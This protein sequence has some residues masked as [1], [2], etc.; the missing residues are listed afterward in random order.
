MPLLKA[1]NISC[2][3]GKNTVINNMSFSAGK[4]EFLGII[5][6]NG[7]GKT[8]LFRAITR[9]LPLLSGKIT[10]KEQKIEKISVSDFAREV[11][12]VPQLLEVSFAFTVEEFILMGRFPYT[13]RFGVLKKRDY[14]V[15]E[16]VLHLTDMTA[17]R[18]RRIF[19]LSGGERQ[20]AVLAQ[21]LAQEPSLLLMDEPTAHL[22]IGHQVKTLD[23]VARL[24]REKNLT[25]IAVLHD[26]NLAGSYCRQLLLL[27]EGNIFKMGSPQE[28]LTYANIEEVYNTVVLVKENPVTKKPHIFLV[29][30]DEKKYKSRK[31]G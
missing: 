5:G 1:E 23:V 3:Y 21:G 28:V 17:F 20:R 10:Y 8:T 29:S 31:Y 4:G 19:E 7:A 14:E 27:K 22:D 26:L 13:G 24:N 15:L 30:E 12:V 25:V 11:A 2:G 18:K 16:E 6:P 9:I